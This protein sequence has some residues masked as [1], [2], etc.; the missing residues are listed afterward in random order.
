MLREMASPD[1]SFPVTPD[2]KYFVVRGRLWRRANPD[3]TKE[4]RAAWVSDLM[5]ARRQVAASLRAQDAQ[6]QSLARQRVDAAKRGLGERGPV[7]WSDG[8][9]DYNRRMA[10]NTPYAKWYAALNTEK[11]RLL[12]RLH[13]QKLPTIA[14]GYW[15]PIA[16]L[17]MRQ[18]L[19]QGRSRFVAS[20]TSAVR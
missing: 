10:R 3:L 5:R 1:A 20:N 2:S 16:D 15:S 13:G 4:E 19:R 8:T 14:V 18:V 17:E 6:A 7:W 11:D 9:P 12:K